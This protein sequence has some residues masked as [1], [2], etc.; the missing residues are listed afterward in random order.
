MGPALRA[1]AVLAA[2]VGATSPNGGS[3][4]ARRALLYTPR[5]DRKTIEQATTLG[6]DCICMDMGDGVALS[7]KAEA[8]AVIARAMREIDFGR[9]ERCIR[10]NSVGSGLEQDD[11]DVALDARPDSIVVPK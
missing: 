11:L 7:R 10:I 1:A 9:S 2:R 8:R 6:L 4:R 5:D 3:M